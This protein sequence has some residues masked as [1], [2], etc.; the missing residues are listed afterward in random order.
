ME[1][2]TKL[3]KY[4]IGHLRTYWCNCFHANEEDVNQHLPTCTWRLE[5]ERLSK[6]E[7]DTIIV[8]LLT[9]PETGIFYMRPSDGIVNVEIPVSQFKKWEAAKSTWD[10]ARDEMFEKFEEV[11]RRINDSSNTDGPLWP[12]NITTFKQAEEWA[13]KFGITLTVAG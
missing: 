8:S 10:N 1:D 13:A 12:P 9:D 7:E 3:A 2:I 5:Y 11:Q 4:W 6:V